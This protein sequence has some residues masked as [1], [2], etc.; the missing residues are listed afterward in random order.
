MLPTEPPG[1]QCSKQSEKSFTSCMYM[2][3]LHVHV[4]TIAIVF[5]FGFNVQ[6]EPVTTTA[7]G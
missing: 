7:V 2:Y 6:R 1:S 5:F 4:C 3:V